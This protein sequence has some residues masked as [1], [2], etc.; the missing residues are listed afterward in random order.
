M[1]NSKIMNARDIFFR[2]LKVKKFIVIVFLLVVILLILLTVNVNAV[3]SPTN[4][5]YVND[6]ADV[7][8]SETEQYIINTNVNLQEQT[9]AQVVV[10]NVPTSVHIAD[11]E[12]RVVRVRV[13]IT[14]CQP[15]CYT[16]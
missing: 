16:Q 6:Y 9:G 2:N 7:L 14:R 1:F 15:N 3:V 12:V 8:S 5:F 10:V 4:D 11:I 13:H